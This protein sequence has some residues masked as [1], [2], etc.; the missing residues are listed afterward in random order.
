MKKTKNAVKVPGN[1]KRPSKLA[2]RRSICGGSSGIRTPDTLLKRQT[3]WKNAS[4]LIEKTPEMIGVS[5]LKIRNC[6]CVGKQG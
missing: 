3:L 6:T 1:T 2:F 4:A 5:E